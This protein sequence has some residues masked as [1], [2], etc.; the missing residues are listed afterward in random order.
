VARKSGSAGQWV[1]RGHQPAGMITA[2]F[3]SAW[4]VLRP[5][6]AK[7]GGDLIRR[8]LIA[9]DWTTRRGRSFVWRF[10]VNGLSASLFHVSGSP[11]RFEMPFIVFTLLALSA[12][13][14][15]TQIAA[16]INQAR[17]NMCA[18]S[19]RC[20]WCEGD[21]LWWGNFVSCEGCKKTGK[22]P[23]CDGWGFGGE[24]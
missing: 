1:L 4:R 17:C 3:L 6:L 22:C 5:T 18:G 15:C 7:E 13:V 21:G 24:K 12:T 8:P 2:A 10:P 19:G 16:P 9:V 20:G 14:G 11:R 23:N